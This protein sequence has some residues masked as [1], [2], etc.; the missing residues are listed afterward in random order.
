MN[1]GLCL[2]A[3]GKKGLSRANWFLDI[4]RSGTSIKIFSLCWLKGI[5]NEKTFATDN[6]PQTKQIFFS[7]IIQFT[8]GRGLFHICISEIAS[9]SAYET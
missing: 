4:L 7:P 8:D 6:N 9:I 3:L 2:F 1:N 5:S